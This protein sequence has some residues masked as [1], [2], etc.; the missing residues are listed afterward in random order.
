[1]CIL[2]REGYGVSRIKRRLIYM[3][4]ELQVQLLKN[5]TWVTIQRSNYYP[6][7]FRLFINQFLEII[8]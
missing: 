3:D 7:I 8:K 1:M 4:N 6:A 5:D 2:I